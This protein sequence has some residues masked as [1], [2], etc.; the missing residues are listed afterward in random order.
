VQR[1]L[2]SYRFEPSAD[3]SEDVGQVR[4]RFKLERGN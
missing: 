3:S 1:A 4:F 2:Y